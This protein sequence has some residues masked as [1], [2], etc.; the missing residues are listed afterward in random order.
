LP[1]IAA[2]CAAQ[3]DESGIGV[4]VMRGGVGDDHVGH[5]AGTWTGLRFFRYRY[6][7]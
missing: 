3:R 7:D 6:M 4:E 1:R 5:V 2:G